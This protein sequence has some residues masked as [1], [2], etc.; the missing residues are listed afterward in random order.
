MSHPFWLSDSAVKPPNLMLSHLVTVLS[1][2]IRSYIVGSLYL[3]GLYSYIPLDVFYAE[4]CV[5][6]PPHIGLTVFRKVTKW[7]TV[8]TL[9]KE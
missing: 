1:A 7:V 5:L 6:R 4:K 3:V 2:Y 9:T 8:D